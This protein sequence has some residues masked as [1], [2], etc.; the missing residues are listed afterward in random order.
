MS[1]EISQRLAE[2]T[3]RAVPGHW[4]GDPI[5][6]LGSAAIGTLVEHDAFHDAIAS[7][8]AR[9]SWRTSPT[10]NG[11]ALAGHGAEAVREAVTRA[12][13]TL[14][15]EL[16]RSLTWEQGAEM[17][18]HDRLKIDAGV[19]IYFCDPQSPWQRF[20]AQ[21]LSRSSIEGRLAQT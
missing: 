2:A 4:E 5:L 6:G 1:P 7:S 15:Q 8:P 16:R 3:D 17:A 13:I 18:Q 11:P 14:P 12:I 9:R 19:Q 20:P 10:K 21:S